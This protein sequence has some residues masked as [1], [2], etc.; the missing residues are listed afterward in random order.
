MLMS[1][2]AIRSRTSARLILFS[3][4]DWN[5]KVRDILSGKGRSVHSI[6]RS[7]TLADVVESLVAHNCGSLVVC[8][9][10]E[11]VGIITE[12]DILRAC[13]A[14]AGKLAALKVDEFMTHRVI[15][16]QVDDELNAV[17]SVMTVNR[18][19]HLPIME[20]GRLAGLISIGDVVK[21]HL[22]VLTVENNYLM[23]YIQS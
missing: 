8:E 1:R 17:M 23:N 10:D 12:R 6:R 16:G 22:D 7:A 18:V 20:G 15:T 5:V 4:G 9:G 21:R 14:H 2:A 3:L 19:R 11:L 13:A